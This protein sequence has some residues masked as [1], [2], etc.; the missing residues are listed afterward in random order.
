MPADLQ[1]LPTEK[2]RD[3][4]MNILSTHLETLLL[5]ST[6]RPG[7]DL[8]RQSGVYPIIR[9]T[10]LHVSDETVRD[11]CDRVVQLLMRDEAD[12]KE[13]K[14]EEEEEEQKRVEDAFNQSL[15]VDQSATA[16]SSSVTRED[17]VRDANDHGKRQ[18]S[19]QNLIQEDNNGDDN[20]DDDEDNQIVEVL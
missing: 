14:E 13:E 20:D 7:R 15:P 19:S 3:P 5:F 17:H 11:A 16:L 6:T 10:H 8:L 1:L 12:V 4:N 18:V 2:Q 9:E